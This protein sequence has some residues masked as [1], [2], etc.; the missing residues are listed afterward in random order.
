MIGTR[1]GTEEDD[2]TRVEMVTVA[3][4]RLRVATRGTGPPLLLITGIGANIEMWQP[5]LA[6]IEDR[7]VVAFDAPG[8]GNSEPG[9]PFRM[10]DLARLVDRLLDE[11]GLPRADVL[12]YSWGGAVAQQLAHDFPHRV[13]R[14]VLAGTVCGLGSVPPPPSVL[15]HL[16]H[17]LRYYSYAYLRAVAP[18]LFG[19]RSSRDPTWLSGHARQRQ[20]NPPSVLGYALQMLAISGWTSL[21][22]LHTIRAPTLVLAG[23]E[24]PIVPPANARLLSRCIPDARLHLVRGGGHLFPLDQPLQTVGVLE[25]FLASDLP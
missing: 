20:V 2:P 15:L 4:R 24:D 6:L 8:S 14:L 16:L 18:V 25:D 7:H 13:R 10:P 11:L 21:P 9:A 22:W 12:G 3:G 1:G 23:D 17:P 5:L 19:G